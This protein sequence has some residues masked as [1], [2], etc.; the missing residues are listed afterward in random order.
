[1][2]KG[3]QKIILSGVAVAA[4]AGAGF[5]GAHWWTEGRFVEATDNAYVQ[6]HITVVSPRI[7]DARR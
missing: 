6:S 5:G 7:T 1:M 3:V 4:L 2:A